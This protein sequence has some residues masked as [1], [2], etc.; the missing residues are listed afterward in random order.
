MPRRRNPI[1]TIRSFLYAMTRI[2]GDVNAIA[3]GP[4]ATVKRIAR[5]GAGK[6][7]GRMLGRLFR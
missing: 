7:T 1:S 3:R 6:L 4:R 2:L 5:R